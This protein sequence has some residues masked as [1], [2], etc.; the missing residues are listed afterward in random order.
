[1]KET[2]IAVLLAVVTLVPRLVLFAF[3]Q[4][5]KPAIQTG[6]IL[7]G[8]AIDYHRRAL[9]AFSSTG[10]FPPDP[11]VDPTRPPL[12]PL[13]IALS[14]R[15][16]GPHV[17][18]PLLLQSV[19]S[20]LICLLLYRIVRDSGHPKA[21]LF[22]ALAFALDPLIVMISN[23]L[24]SETLFLFFLLLALGS[25][26][27]ALRRGLEPGSRWSLVASGVCFGLATLTRPAGLVI[28]VVTAV[29]FFI[30]RPRPFRIPVAATL[31][32]AVAFM[33]SILPWMLRNRA[34]YGVASVSVIHEDSLLYYIVG[35]EEVART[36]ASIDDV[37]RR[38]L[39]EVD[40]RVRAAGLDPDSL[41]DFRRSTYTREVALS[42]IRK[43]PAVYAVR[44]VRGSVFSLLNLATS[45]YARLLRLGGPEGTAELYGKRQSPAQLIGGWLRRKSLGEQLFGA[46]T[47]VW[48]ALSYL[49]LAV[50]VWT[51]RKLRGDSFLIACAALALFFLVVAAG[52]AQYRFR[53]AAQLFYLPFMGIGAAALW[54][55]R[56]GAG[57]PADIGV[58]Q[59]HS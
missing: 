51:S 8:D 15:L 30:V 5:W 6:V 28:P 52:G 18:I 45:E 37:T 32:L 41:N 29:I 3:I 39:H 24:L 47:A 44:F 56:P 25:L 50:G 57:A 10:F 35:F 53:L 49:C 14:Y 31:V 21:A 20:V 58:R 12:Y 1:M 38:L 9:S 17:W 22:A 36:G 55:H 34:T 11:H 4:S 54:P 7:V 42:Y 43:S 48:L 27:A 16:G 2:R 19:L 23:Q 59:A 33:A 13:F 26:Q 40:L 46:W